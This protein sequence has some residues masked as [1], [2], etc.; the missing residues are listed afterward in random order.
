MSCDVADFLTDQKELDGEGSWWKSRRDL[1]SALHPSSVMP[2]HLI[3]LG[4]ADEEV[5]KYV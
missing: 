1:P 2:F 4:L 5:S 3:G